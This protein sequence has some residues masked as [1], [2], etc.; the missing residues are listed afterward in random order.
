[1]RTGTMADLGGSANLTM[2]GAAAPIQGL[3][4]LGFRV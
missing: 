1:L 4:G 2:R 3:G